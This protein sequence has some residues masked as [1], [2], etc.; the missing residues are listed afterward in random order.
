MWR[1]VSAEQVRRWQAA[2]RKALFV[3][4]PLPRLDAV[5]H[6]RFEPDPGIVAERIS[7]AT[8]FGLRV[9]AI[10]YAR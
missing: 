9:P 6:G 5:I 7:Y 8:Q 10:V 1:S 3:S 4:D 2:I